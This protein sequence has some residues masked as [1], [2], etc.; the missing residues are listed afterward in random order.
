MS[1]SGLVIFPNSAISEPGI[2]LRVGAVIPY[3]GKGVQCEM[4][5]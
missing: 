1:P 5:R 2:R 3:Q 4:L